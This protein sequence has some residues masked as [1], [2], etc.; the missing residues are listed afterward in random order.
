M[1]KIKIILLQLT[2]FIILLSINTAFRYT[3]Q[4]LYVFID[5]KI[6]I[7]GSFILSKIDSHCTMMIFYCSMFCVE[8]SDNNEVIRN[9]TN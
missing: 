9:E 5:D 4:H 8:N 6:P 3:M 7:I 2:F 1:G